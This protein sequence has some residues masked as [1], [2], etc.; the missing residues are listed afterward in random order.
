MNQR[1]KHLQ[2]LYQ[3]SRE[4]A[5]QW[6][7]AKWQLLARKPQLSFDWVIPGKLAVGGL[8]QPGDSEI[9]ERAGIKVVFS[10]CSPQEGTPPQDVLDRFYCLRLNLPD[11]RYAAKLQPAQLAKAVTVVQ[12][13]MKKRWPIYIH[14]LAGIERSPTV[15]IAYLCRYENMEVWEALRFLKQVHPESMP[16][17]T[18]LYVLNEFLSRSK[19]ANA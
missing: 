2:G 6:L 16:T 10:L 1:L 13:S 8:P 4:S 3:S 17:E 9:L 19:Q 12:K 15:C 11:S 7:Q 5:C 18:Q 14:C